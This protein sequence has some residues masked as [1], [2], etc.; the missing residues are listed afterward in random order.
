MS[1][2]DVLIGLLLLLGIANGT[3]I[4]AKKI[5]GPRWATP[6]DGGLRLPDGRPV[7]GTSKTVRGII[8]SITVTGLLAPLLG[9][10]W[11]IGA[12][13]AAA[14]MLG[15]LLSSFIKRRLGVAVHGRALGLD[16]IPEALLPLLLL[17]RSLGIGPGDIVLL[18]L[19]FIVLEL[20]LSRI[21]FKLHLRDRPY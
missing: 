14:S 12:G 1:D 11:V 18:V 17:Q 13:L 2:L 9:F 4:F 15:D 6:V 16:Q 8:L 21:L 5:L 19:A 3:P 20:V 10:D 7:F